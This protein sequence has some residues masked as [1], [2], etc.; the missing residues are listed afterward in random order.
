M[1]ICLS[2]CLMVKL[3][4]PLA[5]VSISCPYYYGTVKACV[6]ENPV[7]EVIL[8]K[9]PGC[10]LDVAAFGQT[11]VKTVKS[12]KPRPL[13]KTKVMHVDTCSPRRKCG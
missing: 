8:G 7:C 4:L 3:S 11:E 6:L 12:E 1:R 9:I 5:V 13:E 10:S 2:D